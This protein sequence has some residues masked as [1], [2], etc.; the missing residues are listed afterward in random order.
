M[1]PSLR[2]RRVGGGVRQHAVA[3]RHGADGRDR[4]FR[5]RSGA[6]WRAAARACRSTS[7]PAIGATASIAAAIA[8]KLAADRGSTIKA[9]AVV[10][11]ETSTGVTSDIPAV[12]RA[13]DEAGHPALLLVDADL[14][15]RLDRLPPRRVARRRDRQQLA[16][17][18]DAAAGHRLQRD[19][20][21]ARWPRRSRR[22]LPRAYWDW[23]P[24]IRDNAAG[25]FPYTPATN[26][27]YGLREA[28]ADA[29][30]GRAARTCFARHARHGEATRR[31]VRGVGPRA[32]VRRARGVQQR[33]DRRR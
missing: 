15:A 2:H 32:A 22:A 27:L 29:R 13:M 18:H 4:P 10:H 23:Q 19:Q 14:V 26:L 16:E 28:L 9:V 7:S 5:R 12:R 24:M 6:T 21:Q 30:R 25:F 31:A 33:A 8:E 1:Y 17:G 3:R 11:N 20:R